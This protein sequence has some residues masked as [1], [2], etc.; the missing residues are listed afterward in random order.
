M[1][2]EHFPWPLTGFRQRRAFEA[3]ARERIRLPRPGEEPLGHLLPEEEWQALLSRGPAPEDWLPALSQATGVYFFPSRE[4]PGRFIRW[5]R[6][7]KVTRLL[8]AGAGRGYLTAA[9]APLAAAAGLQFKAVDN[10]Q[11]EFQSGLA[12]HP[13]VEAADAFALVRH[14]DPQAVLYAWPPPGQSLAPLFAAPGLRLIIVAGEGGGGITGARE[15]Y[16]TL[17]WRKSAAL[18]RFCRG[19]TGQIR[20]EVTIFERGAGGGKA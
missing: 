11:G 18:S 7:C 20:H 14:Y 4:W 6:L 5:L 19:R 13:G 16:L 17:P 8:E 12:R 2:A 15:D 1:P 3:W 9:L 10:S